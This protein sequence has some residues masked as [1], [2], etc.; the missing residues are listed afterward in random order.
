MKPYWILVFALILSGLTGCGSSSAPTQPAA[1]SSAPSWTR[2]HPERLGQV[3]GVAAAEIYGSEANAIERAGEQARLDLLSRIRVTLEGSSSV[4]SRVEL[5]DDRISGVQEVLTQQATSRVERVQL[6]GIEVVETWVDPRATEA[7]ALARF[8]R[9]Q[10]EDQLARELEQSQERLLA[11]GLPET[12][13]LLD[14]VREVLP[15]LDDL[16]R[17]QQLQQQLAFLGVTDHLAASQSKAVD[18]LA[19]DIQALLARVTFRIDSQNA[20]AE[21]LQPELA[22]Q[23]TAMGFH[24]VEAGEVLQLRLNLTM[25]SVQRDTLHHRIVD[26][27]GQLVTAEGHTLYALQER[28]RATSTDPDTAT[29]QALDALAKGLAKQLGEG[30]YQNL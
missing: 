20:L 27:S 15:S 6:P 2:Q 30:L 16:A 8:D 3:Y 11:R 21:R 23:L 26:V 1:E 29:R 14:Q 24:L 4:Q 5:E 19:L 22:R 9:I 17:R 25:D 12:G 18:R 7:W 13:E 10:A 28:G